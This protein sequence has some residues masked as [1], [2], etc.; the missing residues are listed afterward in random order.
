MAHKNPKKTWTSSPHQLSQALEEWST[1]S[2]T[3]KEEGKVAHDQKMLKDIEG[4]LIELKSKLE[5]L[6][7]PNPTTP[8]EDAG[9]KT[10]D[11]L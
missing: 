9:Q 6:S 4:L 3:V 10:I 7:L 1:I 8:S 11:P 5:E 2:K